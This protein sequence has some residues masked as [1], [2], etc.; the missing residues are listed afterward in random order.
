[1]PTPLEWMEFFYPSIF[2]G[3]TLAYASPQDIAMA[4]SVAENFRPTC[5]PA[6]QQ[7]QAQAH[8][9]SYVLQ[10][11]EAAK[12]VGMTATETATAVVAGPIIEKQE[13]TTRVRYSE[14]VSTTTNNAA[15]ALNMV[16]GPGT[17]YAAWLAMWNMCLGVDASGAVAKRGGIITRF[18]LPD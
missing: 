13:G 11:R 12:S 15:Q 4:L 18:G 10:F 17:P 3:E 2:N 14:K 16:S 9:A 1:M 5:L 7:N 8:Y 6:D